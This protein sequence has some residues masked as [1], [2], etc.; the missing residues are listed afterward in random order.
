MARHLRTAY[1]A[2][3]IYGR[4]GTLPARAEQKVPTQEF[5]EHVGYLIALISSCSY[6]LYLTA[7]ASISW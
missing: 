2:A 3:G 4:T 1:G 5:L 7:T 6:V